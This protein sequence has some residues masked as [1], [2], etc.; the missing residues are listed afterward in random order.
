MK[1]NFPINRH[2]TLRHQGFTLME[3]L[4]AMAI[5]LVVLIGAL[6]YFGRGIRSLQTGDAYARLHEAGSR[7]SNIISRDLQLAGFYGFGG[8]ANAGS[9]MGKEGVTFSGGTF[10]P[11]HPD[12]LPANAFPATC[13]ANHII[14]LDKPIEYYP[15]QPSTF[16]TTCLPLSLAT[17]PVLVVRGALDGAIIEP[18]SGPV[19]KTAA[20]TPF[21][22]ANQLYITANPYANS[23]VE[24]VLYF[25]GNPTI[26]DA[27]DVPG[28]T[29][30]YVYARAY[31][32]GQLGSRRSGARM[33]VFP[34]TYRIYYIRNCNNH[35]IAT[36]T[37]LDETP[38]PSL[39]RQQL[40]PGNADYTTQL[41][42]VRMIPGIQSMRFFWGMDDRGSFDSVDNSPLGDGVTDYWSS[43]LNPDDFGKVNAVRMQFLV[44]ASQID[45]AYS[46]TENQ[47]YFD[48]DTTGYHCG[49]G[50]E[51]QHRR[52]IF[53][54]ASSVRN[55]SLRRR[56]GTI[57]NNDC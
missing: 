8:A 24:S 50:Q 44:R 20:L 1:Q 12:N 28:T 51:C 27:A 35:D 4:I 37:C 18:P 52:M 47:Y 30:A 57:V 2:R 53:E 40:T 10:L 14:E 13:T 3:V 39:V 41:E 6:T 11:A 46:D 33:P 5:G 55:C 25:F 31:I 43:A 21:L 7:A 36:N 29:P 34:Y 9:I 17:E 48:G 19:P 26:A 42:L 38:E 56:A 49:T 32:A 54:A 23:N 22:Q 15:S 16:P 45:P